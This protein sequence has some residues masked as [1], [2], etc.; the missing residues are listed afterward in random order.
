MAALK[1]DRAIDKALAEGRAVVGLNGHNMV[2][3][4]LPPGNDFIVF[5]PTQAVR[6]AKLLMKHA[7][8]SVRKRRMKR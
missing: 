6:L 4:R 8:R 3:I 7:E 5:T 1:T 2:Q